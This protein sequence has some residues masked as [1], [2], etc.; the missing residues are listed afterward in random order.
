MS[1]RVLRRH[2]R[3]INHLMLD[4]MDDPAFVQDLFDFVV[5][6]ELGFAR[7][8]AQAGVELMGVGDAAVSLAGPAIFRRLIMLAHKKL[9]DG[10]RAMGLRTRSHM[11]G[12][13]RKILKERGELGYDMIE[14]D[15]MVP[16]ADARL[17][18][19][20]EVLIGNVGTVQVLRNG[21]VQDVVEAVT[22]CREDA[23]DLYIIA[24]GCEVPRDTPE[25]NMLAMLEFARAH[26]P[27]APPAAHS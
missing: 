26:K 7:A 9:V 1:A 23:G 8:Q 4:F 21:C 16:M 15:S 18:M 5:E 11:C 12:N 20:G 14:L 10:L 17:N 24:A 3:G 2:L 22:K 25:E 19:P 27:A 6:M 13:T